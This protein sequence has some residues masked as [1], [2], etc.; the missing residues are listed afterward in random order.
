MMSSRQLYIYLKTLSS[1]KMRQLIS[2]LRVHGIPIK[3]I[4]PYSY[5]EM[6]EAFHIY[7]TFDNTNEELDYFQL[8]KR[9][10]DMLITFVNHIAS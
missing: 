8:P 7:F 2:A 6:P 4:R 5:P 9:D 1:S 3:E 10:Y